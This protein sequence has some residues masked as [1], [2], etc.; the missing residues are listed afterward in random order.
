MSTLIPVPED[1]LFAAHPRSFAENRYVY[2]VVSR[3]AGGVSIGVNLSR[4]KTCNFRCVYC[5]VERTAG[6]SSDDL[7][8]ARAIELPRLAAEL[9]AAIGLAVSGRLFDLP[10]FR[11]TP[12]ALRRLNDLALSGDGEPTACPQFEEAVNVLVEARDRHHLDAVKL[13]LI[14]NASLLHVERVRR[15]MAVLAAHGGEVWAKLDAGTEAYYRQIARATV[16]WPQILDNL[17]QTARAQPIVIQSLFARLYDRPPPAEEIAAYA[18]RLG[19]IVAAGG[20]IKLVQIH[21]V[22]RRTAESWVAPLNNAEVDAIAAAV[23]RAT[24]LEV[25]TYYS[26]P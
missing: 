22:A 12:P 25:A 14:T 1:R 3:R 10:P 20:Q 21:T 5:Q 26:S 13:V 8:A 18:E 11:A 16:P 24:G 2:P 23:R 9:D 19:E 6:P 4:Q 7:A 17:R 15:A